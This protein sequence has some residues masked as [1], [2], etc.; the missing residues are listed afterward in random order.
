MY[1]GKLSIVGPSLLFKIVFYEAPLGDLTVLDAFPKAPISYSEA[2]NKI[3][4][5]TQVKIRFVREDLYEKENYQSYFLTF[6][7]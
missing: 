7:K 5:I 6:F 3:S 2:A 1:V 4:S